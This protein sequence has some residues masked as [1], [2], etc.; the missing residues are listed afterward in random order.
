MKSIFRLVLTIVAA[1]NTSAVAQQVADYYLFHGISN[2]CGIFGFDD[3]G[4][5]YNDPNSSTY[6]N[7][8]DCPKSGGWNNLRNS[9][10]TNFGPRLQTGGNVNALIRGSSFNTYGPINTQAS[11]VGNLYLGEMNSRSNPTIVIG[12]SMGGLRARRFAQNNSS[13]VYG[14][15]TIGSPNWGA[16]IIQNVPAQAAY[17]EQKAVQAT[18]PI[19]GPVLL[20]ARLF[21]NWSL[22]GVLKDQ[23]GI[24]VSGSE[25]GLQDMV[26]N[27]DFLKGLNNLTCTAWSGFLWWWT[28]SQYS[29]QY[30]IPNNIYTASI[31]GYNNSLYTLAPDAQPK[32]AEYANIANNTAGILAVLVPLSFGILLPN[33]IAAV[34]LRDILYNFEPWYK[35][36]VVGSQQGDAVVPYNSQDIYNQNVTT[37]NVLG[38]QGKWVYLVDA[39]HGGAKH[40]LDQAPTI[41]SVRDFQFKV[42]VA[43]SNAY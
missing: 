16:P 9:N 8:S 21:F 28:C 5:N 1:I 3:S 38:G 18:F 11:N 37:R 32:I 41:N 4:R 15:I 12:H 2:T 40:E 23:V 30:A 31:I 42:T 22:L 34:E 10:T 6:N 27:S 7:F 36:Y 19:G 29:P 24:A 25:P 33:F 35:T 39:T 26:P 20:F 14:M 43:Q 17:L 13:Q